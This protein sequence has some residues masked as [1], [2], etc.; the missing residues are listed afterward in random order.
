MIPMRFLTKNP[1]IVFFISY[2]VHEIIK[3]KKHE[4]IIFQKTLYLTEY[5]LFFSQL[6]IE[7]LRKETQVYNFC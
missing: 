6:R 5:H 4:K 3:K 2:T 1:L 7:L